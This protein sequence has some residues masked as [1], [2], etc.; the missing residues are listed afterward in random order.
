MKQVLLLLEPRRIIT[1]LL[2]QQC[3]LKASRVIKT[4]RLSDDE[5]VR[6]GGVVFCTVAEENHQRRCM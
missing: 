4:S 1:L 6:S 5:C 3:A 2:L